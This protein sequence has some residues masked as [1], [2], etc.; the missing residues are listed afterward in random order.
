MK[1]ELFF[2]IKSKL[3]V[4]IRTTVSH[5]RLIT[6]YKHPEIKGQEKAVIKTLENPAE[7]RLS[8]KDKKVYLYYRR[9]KKYFFCVVAKHLNGEGFVIT[10]YLS[11]N[12]KEGV[13]LW[14]K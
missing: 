13:L 12:I 4:I 9:Q 5:W 10:A 2:E 3:K 7:I 8:R 14:K 6:D 11:K 1:R